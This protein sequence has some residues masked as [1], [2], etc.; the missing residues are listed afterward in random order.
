MT[1]TRAQIAQMVD[2]T[3]LTPQATMDQVRTLVEEAKEWGTASVCISPSMLPLPDDIDL[4]D[5]KLCVV[6]GFPSGAV[7]PEIKAAEAKLSVAQGADEVD[8]VVNLRHVV[9]G[10]FDAVQAEL[11]MIREAIPDAVLKVIIEAAA[12][13]DEQIVGACRAAAA[14]SADFVKTSTGYHKAGGASV[15]AVRLMRETVGSSMGV[16]AAGGIHSAE[17]ALA[18][19][20]AGANRLGLSGTKKVLDGLR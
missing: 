18:M 11:T 15:H 12:L 13:T 17:E 6:N 14:A 4:G 10:D 19:V 2:H 20:E 3:L 9:E 7:R 5:V 16:K 8:T 1:Y